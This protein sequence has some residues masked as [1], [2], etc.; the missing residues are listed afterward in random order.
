MASSYQAHL[1]LSQNPPNPQHQHLYELEQ[2]ATIAKVTGEN[3]CLSVV[4]VM[5]LVFSTQGH[6]LGVTEKEKGLSQ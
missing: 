5:E 1:Q 4:G 3:W 2:F 6:V